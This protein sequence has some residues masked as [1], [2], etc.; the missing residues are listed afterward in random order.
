M[1]IAKGQMRNSGKAHWGSCCSMRK[2]KQVPVPLFTP[3]VGR[4]LSW[5]L[6]W[7]ERGTDWWVRLKGWLGWSAHPCVGAGVQRSCTGPFCFQR[8]VEVAVGFWPFCSLLVII[9]P[10]CACTQ[11]LSVPCSFF[12]GEGNGT[13]L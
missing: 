8:T 3:P 2:Q 7:D 9:C 10:N 13:P 12:V 5:S 1:E 4:G 11:L 6:K